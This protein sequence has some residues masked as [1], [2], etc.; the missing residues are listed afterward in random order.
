VPSNRRCPKS[1]Q[2]ARPLEVADALDFLQQLYAG[3]N[4]RPIAETLTM[5]L[6]ALLAQAGIALARPR[7]R[8]S[9]T[10]LTSDLLRRNKGPRPGFALAMRGPMLAPT[11][12]N[13]ISLAGIIIDRPA[14]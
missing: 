13:R 1:S 8:N 7:P 11:R 4:S 10:L 2:R 14:G 12:K 5:L 9:R 6:Q 3:C